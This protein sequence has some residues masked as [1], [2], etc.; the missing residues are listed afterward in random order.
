MKRAS[1]LGH[2]NPNGYIRIRDNNG[3]MRMQ[4]NIVWENANGDIPL[5]YDVHHI[6]G[7]KTDNRLS[8]LELLSR[9]DH[10]RKHKGW[11]KSDNIWLKPC[12]ACDE[13]LEVNSENYYF[14]TKNNKNYPVGT[15]MFGECRKCH[16][17]KVCD[18][19]KIKTIA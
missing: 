13:L 17:K 16:I 11:V 10:I 2:L 4:H 1:G 19:R 12:Y 5:G 6:N 7:H 18:A 14:T 3:K 8:N 9:K 15:L